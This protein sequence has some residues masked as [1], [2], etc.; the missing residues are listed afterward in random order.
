MTKQKQ[1]KP[2]NQTKSEKNGGDPMEIDPKRAII[3]QEMQVAKCARCGELKTL[4]TS[5]SALLLP[6]TPNGKRAS[7]SGEWMESSDTA[8]QIQST[9]LSQFRQW[10]INGEFMPLPNHDWPGVNEAIDSQNNI[11]W[12]ATLQN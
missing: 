1:N 2:D 11:S 8:P 9:I 7:I 6:L 4:I 12:G 3:A 5:W 10:N